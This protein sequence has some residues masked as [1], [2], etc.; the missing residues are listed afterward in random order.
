MNRASRGLFGKGNVE[1]LIA[2]SGV[3]YGSFK[4]Q[5][6]NVVCIPQLIIDLFQKGGISTQ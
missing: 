6:L 4:M 1:L 5:N 3:F 2:D